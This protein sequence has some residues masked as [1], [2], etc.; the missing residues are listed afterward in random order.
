MS[1]FGKELR[2]FN[3]DKDGIGSINSDACTGPV[4]TVIHDYYS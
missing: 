2:Y 4:L 3:M 1:V